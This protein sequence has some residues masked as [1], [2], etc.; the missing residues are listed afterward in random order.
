MTFRRIDRRH[1]AIPGTAIRC[2]GLGAVAA[3]SAPSGSP[4]TGRA[5]AAVALSAAGPTLPATGKGRM[6]TAMTSVTGSA[7][8]VAS[9]RVTDTLAGRKG[10][11]VLQ[12][13][14]TVVQ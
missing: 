4:A 1:V 2:L 12:H 6:P 11:F 3:G 10:S 5:P 9:E 14:G 13:S 8:C 7:S